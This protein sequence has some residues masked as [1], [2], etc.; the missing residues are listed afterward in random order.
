MRQG[1]DFDE[2][3]TASHMPSQAG[4]RFLLAA[5]AAEGYDVEFWDIP[6]AHMNAPNDPRFRETMKQPS[7]AYGSYRAP[8]I[9]CVLRRAMTGDLVENA[10]WDT[11]RD[12]WF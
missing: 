8:G 2:T 5:V 1:L 9:M 11:G 4:R 10:Q 12:H 6:G 3:R 7:M